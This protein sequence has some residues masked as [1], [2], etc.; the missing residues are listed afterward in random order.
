MLKI[1]F[2]TNIPSP[3]R[4]NFFNELGKSCDLTVL[5]EKAASGERD[6]SW[7]SFN[8]DNF[9]AVILKG[10]SVRTD[11]AFCPQVVKYISK[12]YDHIVVTNMTTPTGIAAIAYMKQ[13]RIP[14]EI[15]SDGGFPKDGKGLKEKLKKWLI[16]GAT[17]WFSTSAMHDQYYLQYGAKK[18]GIVRYPFTSLYEKDILK[19]NVDKAQLRKKLNITKNKVIICVGQFIYRKGIDLLIKASDGLDPDV[20]IY[21][22]GGK[23]TDEYIKLKE[24]HHNAN[25]HFVDFMPKSE[26]FVFYQASD[27]F[28]L[29]TREDI[30]GLVINE[31]MANGLPVI[32]T[33]RCI[34]GLELVNEKNGAIVPIDDPRILA[35]E[36]NRIINSDELLKTMSNES[37]KK[38]KQYTIENMARTHLCYL[39]ESI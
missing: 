26:L 17:R 28:V 16:S 9:K 12:D 27:V 15:E 32:T 38:I 36:I 18:E 22:V 6:D 30:W 31:A 23:P 2:L 21:I 20:G 7:K 37:L 3:Y 8:S 11:S 33:N 39:G 10:K 13:H 19:S 5:F 25:I 29:P 24:T 4:V 14:Y 34:A 35:E 1:L